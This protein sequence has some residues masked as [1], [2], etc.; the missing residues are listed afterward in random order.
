MLVEWLVE[1]FLET[2]LSVEDKQNVDLSVEEIC[3]VTI[4]EILCSFLSGWYLT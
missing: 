2:V 4:I 3:Q 1:L